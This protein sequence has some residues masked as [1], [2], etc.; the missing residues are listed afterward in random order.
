[1]SATCEQNCPHTPSKIRKEYKRRVNRRRR[2]QE[3]QNPE[4]APRK[5]RYFYWAD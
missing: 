1:M 5:T 2:R 4:E 3:K